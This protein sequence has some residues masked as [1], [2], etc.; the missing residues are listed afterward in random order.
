MQVSKFFIFHLVLIFLIIFTTSIFSEYLQL[1]GDYYQ[2]H[3]TRIKLTDNMKFGK[4]EF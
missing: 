3:F 2:V 1:A 4:M